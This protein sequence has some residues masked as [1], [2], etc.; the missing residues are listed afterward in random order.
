MANLTWGELRPRH[1]EGAVQAHIAEIEPNLEEL[2][3]KLTDED[4]WNLKLLIH[5]HDSFK[6]E[7]EIGVPISHPKSHASLARAFLAEYCDD[8]DPLSMV[9]YQR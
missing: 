5:T 6:A 1:P 9:Q 7:S 3:S 8:A 4:Y 2:R